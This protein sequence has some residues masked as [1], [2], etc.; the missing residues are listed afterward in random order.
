MTSLA[1]KHSQSPWL[2]PAC[3]M[4]SVGYR[5]LGSDSIKGSTQENIEFKRGGPPRD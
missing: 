5:K 4:S 2:T 1:T 3:V